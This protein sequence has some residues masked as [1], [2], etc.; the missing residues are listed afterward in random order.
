MSRNEPMFNFMP[1]IVANLT[2]YMIRTF[3]SWKSG[4]RTTMIFLQLCLWAYNTTNGPMG[5]QRTRYAKRLTVS[6]NRFCR[7][8]G[9]AGDEQVPP[10]IIQTWLIKIKKVSQK[11]CSDNGIISN[12]D[13]GFDYLH[14]KCQTILKDSILI[15]ILIRYL[16]TLIDP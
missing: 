7:K 13:M 9:V 2:K 6:G 10:V 14:C 12:R 11:L 3:F 1:H 8:C 15:S 4:Y 16:K 5:P